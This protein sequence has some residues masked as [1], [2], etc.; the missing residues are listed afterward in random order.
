[1]ID[2]NYIFDDFTYEV[3]RSAVD[4]LDAAAAEIAKDAKEKAPVKTGAL[5]DSIY[6]QDENVYNKKIV[7]HVQY[8]YLQHETNPNGKAF[9]L[10][11]A[12]LDNEEV[13]MEK[14]TNKMSKGISQIK[15]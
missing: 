6:V 4:G 8:A 3:I 14:F 10:R 13:I 1:M 9:Y 15:K 2:K 12:L 11:N 7:S 5:R